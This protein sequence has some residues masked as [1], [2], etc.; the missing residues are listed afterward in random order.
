MKAFFTGHRDFNDYSGIEELIN[1]A[2]AKGADHFYCG[3]A[4]GSDLIFAE[5]LISYR[6]NYTAVVPFPKQ[7]EK[8]G[9]EDKKKYRRILKLA[10]FKV[11]TSPT[12]S[13]EAYHIRNE[14][15]IKH[16]DLC[17]ALYS[18][19]E[20]G[21]T[22]ETLKK[23]KGKMDCIIYNPFDSTFSYYDAPQQLSL[24]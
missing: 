21:G 22:F 14:Y 9:N 23:A 12:Y 7:T 5:T 20:Y 13:R 24:F 2:L 8:W 6:L 16:S 18:G 10:R 3:M 4:R 1:K 19:R 17:L 11:C 15:M